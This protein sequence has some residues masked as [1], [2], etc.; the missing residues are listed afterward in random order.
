MNKTIL[1]PKTLFGKPS[2]PSADILGCSLR[3]VDPAAAMFATL[4]IFSAVTV[5]FATE[6]TFA[7]R[8]LAGAIRRRK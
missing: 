6:S 1:L 5:C 8:R 2:T 7:L 4:F 3:K